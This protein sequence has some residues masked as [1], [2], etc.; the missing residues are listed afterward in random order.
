M[1]DVVHFGLG[2]EQRLKR[3]AGFLE[4][5]PSGMAEAV[6]RQI[7]DREARRLD[8]E[9]AV[10]LVDAS[11]HLEQ[12]RLAGAIR[13]AQADALA[14]VDLPVDGFEQDAIAERFGEGGELDHLWTNVS[15]TGSICPIRQGTNVLF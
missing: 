1:L 9:P 12:R 10:G 14:I 5:G 15:G 7:A 13:A 3:A 2:V 8:H 4:H 6:L 11:Q